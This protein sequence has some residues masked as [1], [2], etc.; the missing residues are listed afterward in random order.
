MNQHEKAWQVFSEMSMSDSKPNMTTF[1][2]LFKNVRKPTRTTFESENDKNYKQDDLEKV[3]TLFF[4][5]NASQKA[6][7]PLGPLEMTE[8]SCD[9][10]TYSAA[11]HLQ[12]PTKSLSG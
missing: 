8:N 11:M 6:R 1:H 4:Q 12:T 5:L 9:N 3:I 7:K 2:L 10:G